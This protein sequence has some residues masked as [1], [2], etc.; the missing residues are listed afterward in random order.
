[1]YLYVKSTDIH[2]GSLFSQQMVF[3]LYEYNGMAHSFC[4]LLKVDPFVIFPYW[5]HM[6]SS[7][8]LEFVTEIVSMLRKK[9]T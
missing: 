7:V 6:K 8:W 1:M 3:L 2:I 5:F 4:V 9:P